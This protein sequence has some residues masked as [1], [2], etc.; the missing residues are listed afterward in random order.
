[1]KT[2][3][4]QNSYALLTSDNLTNLKKIFWFVYGLF[5]F[6]PLEL[7]YDG[8]WFAYFQILI[9]FLLSKEIKISRIFIFFTWIAIVLLSIL[10]SEPSGLQA[11][12]N[13]FFTGLIL[14]AG[15]FNKKTS[16]I[17]LNG[18][19]T[20]AFFYTIYMLYL[21]YQ[22]DIKTFYT[23]MSSREW[24]LDKVI[25]FGNGL[26]ILFSLVMI[27]AFKQKKYLLLIFFFIGGIYTTSRIPFV[28]LG[29]I[30]LGFIYNSSTLRIKFRTFTIL[31]ILLTT[32]LAIGILP[33]ESD[34]ISLEARFSTTD[35][36][37]DVYNLAWESYKDKPILGIGAAK[38]PEYDHAHNSYVQVLTKYGVIGFII[39]AT[40]WY[41][42]YFKNI[43]IIKNLDYILNFLVISISQI[44]L[45]NPNAL[46]LI[47]LYRWLYLK[48]KS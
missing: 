5:V 48:S 12:V 32:A 40:M 8:L 2:L 11:I 34:F 7:L 43:N 41:I 4:F 37:V 18:V 33:D 1:M 20:S 38:L 28:T 36:R 9:I 23:L 15:N 14:I 47:I 39:W 35:D 42:N 30:I 10:L 24:A 16:E 13:P 45:Q 17:I 6:V 31:V 29:I 46:I 22:L 44:G 27:F 25:G 3:N 19:Y 21:A 26:A